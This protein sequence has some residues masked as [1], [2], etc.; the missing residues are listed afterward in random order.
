M[1]NRSKKRGLFEYI[2]PWLLCLVVIVAL[3][4]VFNKDNSVK[5]LSEEEF[6]EILATETCDTN[7]GVC[8]WTSSG[9][10]FDSLAIVEKNRIIDI[11]GSV[12]IDGK[13]TKFTTRISYVASEDLREAINANESAVKKVE[14]VDNL[15]LG[16]KIRAFTFTPEELEPK[17]KYNRAKDKRENKKIIKE[18]EEE[19]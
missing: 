1:N 12:L 10:E 4:F 7:T 13:L 18:W 16:F 9:N 11:E 17:K 2:T 8:T 5:Q 3:I 6:F 14:Y 15:D 19:R